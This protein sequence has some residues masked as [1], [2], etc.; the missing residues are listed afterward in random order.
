MPF[1]PELVALGGQK[2]WSVN[3]V[4]FVQKLSKLCVYSFQNHVKGNK[5]LYIY[6]QRPKK[7]GTSGL[8][9]GDDVEKNRALWF[10]NVLF[11][12]LCFKCFN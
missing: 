10:V 4:V 6:L 8:G 7:L 9:F 11:W 2:S 12:L 3:P 1:H 5:K